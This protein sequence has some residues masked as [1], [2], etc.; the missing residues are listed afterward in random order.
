MPLYESSYD[1]S[2]YSELVFSLRFPEWAL[3]AMEWR[4]AWL[5]S[6]PGEGLV[7]RLLLYRLGQRYV[8]STGPNQFWAH[9]A[10]P[11]LFISHKREDRE[12][13]LRVAEIAKEEEFDFWLDVLDPLLQAATPAHP[14]IIAVLIEI[15][16]LNCSHVL[17]VM[18]PATSASTWVPYEYGRVKEDSVHTSLAACWRHP[19]VR[20]LPEYLHLGEI[21]RS[22]S[23]LRSWLRRER[24]SWRQA[25]LPAAPPA[26]PWLSGATTVLPE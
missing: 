11:R 23:E 21:A 7:A 22:E 3:G 14:T 20:T 19:K 16:L 1:W 24:A 17:A 15:A 26:E 2:E 10:R 9:L 12:R 18:T 25:G 5:R 13:A 6:T 8:E 4:E